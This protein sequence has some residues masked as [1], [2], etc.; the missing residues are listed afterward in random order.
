MQDSRSSILAFGQ[1]TPDI[2][3]SVFVAHGARII[4]DVV[5]G[6]ESSVWFNAVVRG[7][8]HWV[9]LG[10]RVNVQ[11]G[12]VL[13]VTHDTAPLT[14][15]DDVT[16]GH[17]AVVHGCTVRSGCLIGMRAVVL[18]G[19]IVGSQTLIAA[20]SVVKQSMIIPDG[21]LVAGNPAV[22]KRS[23]TVEEKNGLLGSARRYRE[24]AQQ[25][26]QTSQER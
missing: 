12:A 2:H 18:D 15:E 16:I 1:K 21:M 13:H 10:T 9:R 4:G 22:V 17:A 23:L 26:I 6:A 5:I 8:V 11:D 3:P 25:Y 24:Y 20:G 7:D 19:A 14:I